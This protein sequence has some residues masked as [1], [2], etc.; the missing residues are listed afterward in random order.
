MGEAPVENPGEWQRS[1][2]CGDIEQ[3]KEEPARKSQRVGGRDQ[4]VQQR[5]TATGHN[6]GSDQYAVLIGY[7]VAAGRRRPGHGYLLN[8]MDAVM[9]NFIFI[10]DWHCRFGWFSRYFR[11]NWRWFNGR[12]T[13]VP[14]GNCD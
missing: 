7:S 4:F 9:R 11:G 3:N 14:P 10:W 5:I 8:S 1:S 6:C 12:F 13:T 2:G